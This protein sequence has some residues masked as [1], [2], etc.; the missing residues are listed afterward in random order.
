VLPV[1]S[2]HLSQREAGSGM[3]DYATFDQWRMDRADSLYDEQC[4]REDRDELLGLQRLAGAYF[5]AFVK[6]EGRRRAASMQFDSP[7]KSGPVVPQRRD[8]A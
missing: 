1:L 7:S 6:D 3:S 2:G 4:W 5:D 8:V